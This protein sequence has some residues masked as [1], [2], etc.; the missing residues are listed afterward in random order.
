MSN[1]D[2]KPV[3]VPAVDK[4]TI[5]TVT[6][7]GSKDT[8]FIIR[9][10]KSKDRGGDKA[11]EVVDITGNRDSKGR[12]V[13]VKSGS[14]VESMLASVGDGVSVK[15]NLDLTKEDS[16][17]NVYV[18]A[19]RPTMQFDKKVTMESFIP[20][21]MFSERFVSAEERSGFTEIEVTQRWKE[22]CDMK[23]TSK[24][25]CSA[26]GTLKDASLNSAEV[27]GALSSD[28]KNR[29]ATDLSKYAEAAN[30]A[31]EL[32]NVNLRANIPDT[33][34]SKISDRIDDVLV[35]GSLG[36]GNGVMSILDNMT[37]N[38]GA[39]RETFVANISKTLG[40][41]TVVASEYLG[42]LNKLTPKDKSNL[43]ELS[44]NSDILAKVASRAVVSG[45]KN[46]IISLVNDSG[47]NSYKVKAELLLLT[48]LDGTL[49]K[50]FTSDTLEL[51]SGNKELPGCTKLTELLIAKGVPADKVASVITSAN[52][53]RYSS[54]SDE[55]KLGIAVGAKQAM[56]YKAVANQLSKLSDELG[57]GGRRPPDSLDTLLKSGMTYEPNAVDISDS[58]HLS[59]E[60]LGKAELS[61]PASEACRADLLSFYSMRAMQDHMAVHAFNE[62]VQDHANLATGYKD[63]AGMERGIYTHDVYSYDKDSNGRLVPKEG[64]MG[65]RMGNLRHNSAKALAEILYVTHGDKV[66]ILGDKAL[67]PALHQEV[68]TRLPK[69]MDEM[70]ISA[71]LVV[72]TASLEDVLLVK[73]RNNLSGLL[74]EDKQVFGHRLLEREQEKLREKKAIK[75]LTTCVIDSLQKQVEGM[76]QGI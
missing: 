40:M 67:N 69:G 30:K 4:A 50:E 64:V 43:R 70:S 2:E 62:A 48:N 44:G 32:I 53:A 28:I 7:L 58:T 41:S 33:V 66:V 10:V 34:A 18:C 51:Y 16:T 31:V 47:G 29:V 1:S 72:A 61:E 6:N 57:S 76:F 35:A 49:N 38:E 46:D 25:L 71:R 65:E 74:K 5:G 22:C 54:L 55:D 56:E 27:F 15:L 26:I 11:Y 14:Q 17:G 23:F 59:K 20:N 52:P 68:A 8:N 12:S 45:I 75:V 9:R 19:A 42:K 60:Y 3:D 13:L 36:G 73:D 21:P 37:L 24:G 63:E 39:P